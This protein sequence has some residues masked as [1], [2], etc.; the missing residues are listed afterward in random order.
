MA[1]GIETLL[2]TEGRF[3][4]ERVS[5]GEQLDVR[6]A[7]VVVSDAAFVLAHGGPKQ[8]PTIVLL[9]ASADRVAI[10]ARAPAIRAW[11]PPSATGEELIAAV[12]A[13]A[14]RTAKTERPTSPAA[15]IPVAGAAA[16][17]VAGPQAASPA[18][19]RDVAI[20]VFG[21]ACAA[22]SLAMVWMA[23]RP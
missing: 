6:D 4:V 12:H 14:P 11:L 5:T 16:R 13:A 2:R 3:A 1:A 8:A 20:L 18:A 10:E 15:P 23:L 19:A 9:D 22:V 17:K 7:D 21:M